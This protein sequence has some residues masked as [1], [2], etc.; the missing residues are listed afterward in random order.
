MAEILELDKSQCATYNQQLV[1]EL[2][3]FTKVANEIGTQ[4]SG[5]SGAWTGSLSDNF[6][7]QFN[8]FLPYLTIGYNIIEK[9]GK[10]LTVSVNNITKTDERGES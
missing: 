9:S 2:D 1:Q 10:D 3:N 5:L 8:T 7:G 6:I 4:A